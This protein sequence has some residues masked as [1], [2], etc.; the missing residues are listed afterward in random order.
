MVLIGSDSPTLPLRLLHRAFAALENHDAVLGPTPDGGYY[1]IG[2]RRGMAVRLAGVRW[3]TS[4]ALADTLARLLEANM[5]YAILPPWYDV[6]TS[7][8]LRL[9]KTHLS[10]DPEAAPQTTL[11]FDREARRD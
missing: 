5:R 4:N 9:L 11:H 3:S 10:L 6:D 1:V 2:F 8:D 7:E